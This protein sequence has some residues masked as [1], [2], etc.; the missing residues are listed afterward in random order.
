M[1]TS[2]IVDESSSSNLRRSS[3]DVLLKHITLLNAQ[4]QKTLAKLT[5]PKVL[6]LYTGSNGRK[7]L[8]RKSLYIF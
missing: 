7:N 8:F 4:T 1:S 3:N 6:V 5:I 2:S